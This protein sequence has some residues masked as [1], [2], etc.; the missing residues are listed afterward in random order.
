MTHD[1]RRHRLALRGRR[2]TVLFRHDGR[3]VRY[4]I[5]VSDWG[6]PARLVVNGED[7]S[8]WAAQEAAEVRAA[9]MDLLYGHTRRLSAAGPLLA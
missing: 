1:A 2:V 5:D 7:W 9:A 8:C 4:T 3:R 6:A